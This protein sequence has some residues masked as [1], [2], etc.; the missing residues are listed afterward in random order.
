VILWPPANRS[1]GVAKPQAALYD[2]GCNDCIDCT[3]NQKS[4]A[5]PGRFPMKVS[6][7]DA[8]RNKAALLK[9]ASVQV[10]EL[11]FAGINVAQLAKS[12]GL[13]HGAL[14]SQFGSKDELVSAA[15]ASAL[16]ETGSRLPVTPL[17]DFLARYLSEKHR[18]DP[19]HGCAIAALVS[20]AGRQPPNIRSEFCSGVEKFVEALEEKY[21]LSGMEQH[22]PRQAA[23]STIAAIVGALAIS[24]AI[25]SQDKELSDEFLFSVREFLESIPE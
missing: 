1:D 25:V 8:A 12:A 20:E 14:Y 4:Q 21:G 3:R 15:Y 7:E 22:D 17:R 23:I 5:W 9:A 24:R 16:S 11:G 2:C 18:D 10:R 6:K 19:G 13:T